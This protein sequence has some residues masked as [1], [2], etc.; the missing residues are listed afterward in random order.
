MRFC[1]VAEHFPKSTMCIRSQ[2]R[3]GG[4]GIGLNQS[5]IHIPPF[6]PTL[7]LILFIWPSSTLTKTLFFGRKKIAVRHLPLPP[8]PSYADGSVHYKD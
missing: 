3:R 2:V 1:C 7:T 5:L 4:V 8:G 6:P